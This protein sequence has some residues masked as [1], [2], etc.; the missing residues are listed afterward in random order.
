MKCDARQPDE[1]IRVVL[2]EDGALL[3]AGLTDLLTRH[4][5]SVVSTATDARELV[6]AT[7]RLVPDLVVTDVRMPPTFTTEGLR[8]AIELRSR[9]PRLPIIALSQYVEPDLAGELLDSGDGTGIGYLLKD[10]VAD[11]RE[12][13]ATLRRIAAGATVIDPDVVR[14]MVARRRDPLSR[15]SEREREVLALL[16]EGRSNAAIAAELWVSEATVVKHVGNILAK[17]DI[18]TNSAANRRVLAV[19]AYLRTTGLPEP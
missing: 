12:F 16:A 17:L 6:A 2:A 3:R 9:H 4:G 14:Q 8:A 19:L 7:D 18:P 5:F 15:L 11:V 13:N 1:S 10:R